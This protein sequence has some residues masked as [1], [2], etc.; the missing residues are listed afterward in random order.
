MGGLGWENTLPLSLGGDAS[1]TEEIYSALRAAVGSGG[2]GPKDSLE[3]LWRQSKAE[4]IASVVLMKERAI[5]QAFPNVATDHLGV[6]EQ[7]LNLQP[8]GTD[9]DRRV[10]IATAWTLD[11]LA[12][13]PSLETSLRVI[14]SA[15]SLEEI[16]YG[17]TA[18]VHLGK[19]FP[20]RGQEAL[21]VPAYPNYSDDFVLR[22]RYTLAPGQ[23]SL[24]RMVR[25]N[26][27]R[28]LNAVLP[29]WI[30]YYIATGAHFYCGGGADGTSLLGL[31]TLGA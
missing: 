24:E 4:V 14:D 5:L 6:Y 13:M 22:V 28:L 26:A 31:K 20:A 16:A 9:E 27:E 15:F 19:A 23:V 12:D 3:D 29:S 30:D 17:D 25:A 11:L 1:K 2:A 10:A 7:I 8:A 21:G 18:L